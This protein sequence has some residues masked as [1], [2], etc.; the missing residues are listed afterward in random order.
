[1][2]CLIGKNAEIGNLNLPR[3]R[4]PNESRH[5][6]PRVL[7]GCGKL[8]PPSEFKELRFG[9]RE[10]AE[11]A[12]A[13]LNFSLSYW[14]IT[15]FS[16]CRHVN[17]G[18]VGAFPRK[19]GHASLFDMHG[20]AIE[21]YYDRYEKYDAKSP[22]DDP[23][24]AAA[25]PDRVLRGWGWGDPADKVLAAFRNK[26]TPAHPSRDLGSHVARGQHGDRCSVDLDQIHPSET[27]R[28]SA[29]WSDFV[30][31]ASQSR[32]HSSNAA[33]YIDATR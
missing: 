2:G 18:E 4:K 9:S 24:G 22:A 5:F 23:T 13:C 7:D 33:P 21:W 14:F 17:K 19:E 16:D 20:K 29:S 31:S 15:V 11:L 27:F 32:A 10:K 26:F 1:M 28:V 8:R 12:L 30:V 25:V 6:E 3:W